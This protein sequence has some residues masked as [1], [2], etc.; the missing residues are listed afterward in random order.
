M[1]PG[2]FPHAGFV[3]FRIMPGD[4]DANLQRVRDK[5]ADMEPS[6]GTI[7]VLPELW[8]GGFDYPNMPVLAA[9]TP[10][11]LREMQD[12]AAAFDIHLA[13]S[14]AEEA[15]K[16]D[17]PGVFFN[18]LFVV[19][20]QGV[21]GSYRKHKL[22]SLWREDDY[23]SPGPLPE[24][25]TTACGDLAPLI[26]FDLRFPGLAG[27]Q[28]ATG[29][30]LLVISAQWP[31]VRISQWR[32]LVR[33]RAIE[34]QLFVVACNSCGKSG[35]LLLGGHSMIVA[36]DGTILLEAGEGEAGEKTALDEKILY[37]LRARFRTI[38]SS[39]T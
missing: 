22:F 13:G 14:L 1:K 24:P 20:P 33:A 38:D 30:P 2:L 10:E 36:P 25:I 35:D 6:S 16:G 15:G 18:T 27:R 26:C 23:F 28:G 32:I 9:R 37:R 8:A 19:G 3:Q 17:R 31:L 11:M 21:R 12:L 29:V 4:V 39:F 34:N 5:I 7:V